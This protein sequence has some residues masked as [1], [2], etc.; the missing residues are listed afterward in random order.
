MTGPGPT[1]QPAWEARR[2]FGFWLALWLTWRDAVFRP[3]EF[4][5][6]LPPR[7][8]LGPA[9][10]FALLITS[11]AFLINIYWGAIE[12]LVVGGQPTGV[13]A[14]LTGLLLVVLW[15]GIFVPV[16]LGVL[17]A[18]VAI[19]H[20]S[21]LIVGAGRQGFEATFRAVAYASGPA[22]FA[23]FPFF[24]AALSTIWGM[25]LVY[26]GVR[27]VQRTTNGRAVLAFLLPFF[28]FMIF[29]LILG[30]LLATLLDVADLTPPA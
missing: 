14:S 16:Y 7:G 6:H 20:V 2:Q 25:V 1:A 4:F 3:I 24:G 28:A 18:V 10:G 11:F 5:R 9:L 27:E 12:Q 13:A 8:G 21:F 23:I 26:I 15:L 30:I 22:A 19:I 17:F 29:F